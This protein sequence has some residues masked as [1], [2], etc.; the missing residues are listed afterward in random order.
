MYKTKG[1]TM[2][3]YEDTLN[4]LHTI[5][6]HQLDCEVMDINKAGEEYDVGKLDFQITMQSTISKMIDRMQIVEKMVNSTERRITYFK[7]Q[8]GTSSALT[9]LSVSIQTQEIDQR[10]LGQL[11][12]QLK[13]RQFQFDILFNRLKAHL[14]YYEEKMGEAWE[15]YQ[16]KNVVRKDTVSVE[17]KKELNQKE[18][19]K[20]KA[21]Y[22]E[23]Y[24]KIE[25][26]LDNED[27][28]IS[29]E[30]IPAYA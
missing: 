15:P 11:E 29:S 12:K 5:Y 16:A 3:T 28:T 21:F 20:V 26:P 19:D 9:S 18:I 24:G 1:Y 10:Q 17:R 23:N 22:N 2:T 30:L 14:N 27:G 7:D 8:K 4:A 13:A 6:D 25:K